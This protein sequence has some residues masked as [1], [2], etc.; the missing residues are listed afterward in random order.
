MAAVTRKPPRR[1]ARPAKAGPVAASVA[2]RDS[3]TPRAGASRL[4]LAEAEAILREATGL[5]VL[6]DVPLRSRTSLGIGGPAPLLLLPEDLE[7]LARLQRRLT[8]AG[9]PFDYL[10]AGSNLLVA[11]RGPSFVV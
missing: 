6:R 2:A 3:T 11:D 7:G 5:R 1:A 4:R 10:G 8:E 9:I